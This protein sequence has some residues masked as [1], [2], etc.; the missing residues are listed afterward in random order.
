[1]I[2]SLTVDVAALQ[3]LP[4]TEPFGLGLVEGGLCIGVTCGAVSQCNV[5]GATCK[6]KSAVSPPEE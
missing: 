3:R 2:Q 1:M 6:Q 5:V 4:E